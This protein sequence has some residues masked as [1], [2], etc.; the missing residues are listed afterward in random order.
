[1]NRWE[2]LEQVEKV[3]EEHRMAVVGDILIR[4]VH[5]RKACEGRACTI[6]NPSQHHMRD[7]PVDWAGHP[8]PG[9]FRVCPHGAYH[10]DPDQV[11][12]WELVDRK[13]LAIHT[14]DGCCA[15]P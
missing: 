5:N 8:D 13:E 15:K 7:W 6:H 14:C 4:G 2:R 10:P 12:F 11:T 9:L 3:L 1:M